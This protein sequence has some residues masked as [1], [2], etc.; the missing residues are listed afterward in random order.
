MTKYI[1]VFFFNHTFSNVCILLSKNKYT[2]ITKWI[3]IHQRKKWCILSAS[4]EWAFKFSVKSVPRKTHVIY[5]TRFSGDC[6]IAGLWKTTTIS[7]ET[8][9]PRLHHLCGFCFYSMRLKV[10]KDCKV[11]SCGGHHLKQ[12]WNPIAL[13]HYF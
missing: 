4:D 10:Q 12:I 6:W 9:A 13:F 8:F 3:T 11:C 7:I 1:A 5:I 2:S